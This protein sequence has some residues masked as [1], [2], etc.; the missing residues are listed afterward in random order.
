MFINVCNKYLVN[1]H[2]KYMKYLNYFSYLN[3]ELLINSQTNLSSTVV[4]HAGLWGI[5]CSTIKTQSRQM[6][7]NMFSETKLEQSNCS[8]K[9]LMNRIQTLQ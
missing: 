6:V 1:S 5:W 8:K 4:K 7:Y 3:S 2:L 9:R